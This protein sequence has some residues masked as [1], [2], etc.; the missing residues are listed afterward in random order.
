MLFGFHHLHHK[1]YVHKHHRRWVNAYEKIIYF[2]AFVGPLMT[3]PQ[4]TKIWTEQKATGVSLITWAGYFCG[5]VLW[6]IYGALHKE[7]PIIVSN[8]GM[9]VM[10]FFIILGVVLYGS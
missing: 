6:L 4:V 5:A 9:I 3:L 2:G 10:A 8:L 1:N 7:K